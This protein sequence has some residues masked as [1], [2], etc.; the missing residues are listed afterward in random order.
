M[1][2]TLVLGVSVFFGTQSELATAQIRVMPEVA[3]RRTEL[4]HHQSIRPTCIL[5]W[6][7]PITAEM[8]SFNSYVVWNSP[9][10]AHG[11]YYDSAVQDARL[12][13]PSTGS[14]FIPYRQDKGALL[15]SQ[16]GLFELIANKEI[17]TGKRL[18]SPASEVVKFLSTTR[19][20]G[21]VGV[22]AS[23]ISG[24]E[25]VFLTSDKK[26]HFVSDD[27]PA[28]L[29]GVVNGRGLQGTSLGDGILYTR[30]GKLFFTGFDGRGNAISDRPQEIPN[31]PPAEESVLLGHWSVAKRSLLILSHGI[32]TV[33]PQT[34][35]PELERFTEFAVKLPIQ[36]ASLVSD[37]HGLVIDGNGWPVVLDL[38]KDV[39]S[40]ARLEPP[41]E[42]RGIQGLK[43]SH[44][45]TL[46]YAVRLLASTEDYTFK[47]NWLVHSWGGHMWGGESRLITSVVDKKAMEEPDQLF[48]LQGYGQVGRRGTYPLPPPNNTVFKWADVES[49]KGIAVSKEPKSYPFVIKLP[50]ARQTTSVIVEVVAPGAISRQRH[51]AQTQLSAD[52]ISVHIPLKFVPYSPGRW[53][54]LVYSS[55]TVTGWEKIIGALELNVSSPT[56]EPSVIDILTAGLAS[57]ILSWTGLVLLTFG[58]SRYSDTA[59]RFVTSDQG[60]KAAV[61]LPAILLG[62]LKHAQLWVLDRYLKN[63]KRRSSS[64]PSYLPVPLLSSDSDFHSSTQA[65]APPWR[66]G[67]T[68][69]RIWIAGGTGMGKTTL[70]RWVTSKH[71][72]DAKSAEQAYRQWGCIV[73]QFDARDFI[74]AGED[75]HDPAWVVNAMETSLSSKSLTFEGKSLLQRMLSDGVLGVVI[76]GL[77]EASRFNAVKAFSARYPLTPMLVTSQ[78]YEYIEGFEHWQLPPTILDFGKAL[79]TLLLK[80]DTVD[81]AARASLDKSPIWGS[82]RSGYDIKLLSELLKAYSPD[83]PLPQD[84][85]G[86]YSSALEKGWPKS[87]T[88]EEDL[89]TLSAAAWKLVSERAPHADRRRMVPGTDAPG[90]LLKALADAPE[91]D[92]KKPVRLVRR[93][94]AASAGEFEF[95]HDQMHA[96]LAASYFALQGFTV[97][98]LQEMLKRSTIWLRPLEER[99][100][101]WGFVAPLLD[102]AVLTKLHNQVSDVEEW[103]S[104]RRALLEEGVKRGLLTPAVLPES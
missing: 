76:D 6:T 13:R 69:R 17:T 44:L 35:P 28:Q 9:Q 19:A 64:I 102:S 38:S 31:V 89:A 33:K 50:C 32:F 37:V 72:H 93:V 55:H 66:S 16:D 51:H 74:S 85:A 70:V 94:S 48:L 43:V 20:S 59:W 100:T 39:I 73:V 91:N 90:T 2:K 103:D 15:K 30:E 67:S 4:D 25:A 56:E 27:K 57:I 65:V 36:H 96:Y 8:Q 40:R 42:L 78:T 95:V 18:F 104:L 68:P 82:V 75:V 71:F 86:L 3:W 41:E 63:K 14:A 7:E 87:S 46:P 24:K 97:E 84:R 53:G 10:G 61:N 23:A 101:L 81:A 29:V 52:K 34:S 26:I 49:E 22:E 92:Q 45:V 12:F 80:D 99:K 58:F 60:Y 1:L 79:L 54:F 83:T 47:V 5:D 88:Q 62:Y 77:H 11:I 98:Q 21:K